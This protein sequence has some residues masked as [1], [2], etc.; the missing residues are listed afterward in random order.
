M[1]RDLV[2]RKHLEA[3][4]DRAAIW[5]IRELFLRDPRAN[6]ISFA[7]IATSPVAPAKT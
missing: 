2:S 5:S 7:D 1:A 3:D 4:K 6:E